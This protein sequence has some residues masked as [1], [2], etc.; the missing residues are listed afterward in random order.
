MHDVRVQLRRVSHHVGCTDGEVRLRGGSNS[1]EGTVEVCLNGQW[2]NICGDTWD[3]YAARTTCR[4]LG[5]PV[6]G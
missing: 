4:E 5:F 1:S 3:E 2:G 6:A